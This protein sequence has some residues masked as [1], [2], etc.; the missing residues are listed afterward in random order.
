MDTFGIEKWDEIAKFLRML[1][2]ITSATDVIQS[3]EASTREPGANPGE[4]MWYP[5]LA[6]SP[7][8]EPEVSY[9][10]CLGR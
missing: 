3:T 9:V 8:H 7:T 6:K 10:L 2:Q 5:K 4:L 1:G